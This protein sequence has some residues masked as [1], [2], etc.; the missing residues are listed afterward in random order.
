[1]KGYKTEDR[2]SEQAVLEQ[3]QSSGYLYGPQERGRPAANRWQV[4]FQRMK[5]RRVLRGLTDDQLKD[6]GLSR[7][8]A[9]EEARRP[10]WQ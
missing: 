4:F 3:S 8:Q 10:F 7:T 6:V 2:A 5:T 1:M 9:Q